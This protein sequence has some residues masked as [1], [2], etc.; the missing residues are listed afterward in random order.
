M[1]INTFG[2]KYRLLKKAKHEWDA[3]SENKKRIST[4]EMKG[5]SLCLS[6]AQD[7][8]RVDGVEDSE[9]REMGLDYAEGHRDGARVEGQD[10]NERI[11]IHVNGLALVTIYGNMRYRPGAGLVLAP[12][13]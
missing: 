8:E 3:K 6:G 13:S 2:G 5:G 12:S 1:V 7:H 9:F 10:E 11:E 4:T